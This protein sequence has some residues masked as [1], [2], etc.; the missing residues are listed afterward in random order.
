[1]GKLS[2]NEHED[3]KREASLWL[4]KRGFKPKDVHE[5]Y[6][7][8]VNNRVFRVDVVGIN[9]NHKVAI[10]CGKVDAN[11]LPILRLFFDEVLL[12]PY[13]TKFILPELEKRL[14]QKE[15]TIIRLEKEITKFESRIEALTRA[16]ND[17]KKQIVYLNT[18]ITSLKDRK[19]PN[20]Q[21]TSRKRI[22]PKEKW[23][24]I[25]APLSVKRRD[26][27][28]KIRKLRYRY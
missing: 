27:L 26:W 22:K 21:N 10:E 25:G 24:M 9:Q 3:L 12:L 8:S 18:R 11:R 16:L 6:E 2:S 28:N 1:M 7:V 15:S 20:S 4:I 23:G 5:E 13:G 19:C 17:A 14:L